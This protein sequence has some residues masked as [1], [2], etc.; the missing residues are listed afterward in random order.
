VRPSNSL[1][2]FRRRS[3]TSSW[4][5]PRPESPLEL[6][7]EKALAASERTRE[8]VRGF[9]SLFPN[10]VLHGTARE[11]RD[12]LLQVFDALLVGVWDTVDRVWSVSVDVRSK[13]RVVLDEGQAHLW[14]C[15][16]SC[17]RPWS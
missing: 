4:P 3:W 10:G 11:V 5:N 14:P 12:A 17:S 13:H 1:G 6:Y 16:T 8:P 2:R 7:K 15:R 9:T